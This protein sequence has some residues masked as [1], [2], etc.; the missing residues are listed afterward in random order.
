MLTLLTCLC[1]IFRRDRDRLDTLLRNLTLEREAI[2]D[3]MYFAV[4]HADAADE[5]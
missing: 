2:G 4:R 3:G 1:L 5:V